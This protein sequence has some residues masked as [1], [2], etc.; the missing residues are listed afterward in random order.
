MKLCLV[1]YTSYKEKVNVLTE[2]TELGAKQRAMNEYKTKDV[3]EN[4]GLLMGFGKIKTTQE[5][6][7]SLV[8]STKSFESADIRA[9]VSIP[10]NHVQFLHSPLKG[11]GG[12]GRNR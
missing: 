10:S 3:K 11:I 4:P 9:P 5:P 8:L 7:F 6:T 1:V 12:L 2:L